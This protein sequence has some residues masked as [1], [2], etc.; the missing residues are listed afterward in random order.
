MADEYL[1]HHELVGPRDAPVLVLS[2]SL[3]TELSIFDAL[4]DRLADRFRIVRYDLRGHGRSATPP[5]PYSIDDLGAD[6]LTLLDRLE[7]D[8]A[9]LCGV[10]IGGM[11]S[12]WLAARHPRRVSALAVCCTTACFEDEVRE[13]YRQR[14][15]GVLARGIEPIADGVVARWF[16]GEFHHEHPQDVARMRA[17]LVAT[18]P[19]AYAGCCEA[20]A[21]MDLRGELASISADALVI[22]ARGDAATPPEH[23][24]L[25]AERV[26][27]ARLR[28]VD[29]AHLAVLESADVVGAEISS[30]LDEE[31]VADV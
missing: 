23:G 2:P 13:N 24:R 28:L 10:S 3:G 21:E 16:T 14:A 6:V 30:F 12:L 9:A 17:S 7:I 27:D 26:P 4:V 11:A 8:R 19:A 15:A 31:V 22:S 29:G 1:A 18:S 25:I 5:G 20:L